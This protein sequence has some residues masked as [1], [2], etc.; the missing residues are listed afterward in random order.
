MPTQTRTHSAQKSGGHRPTI[1]QFFHSQSVFIQESRHR[2]RRRC[3][4]AQNIEVG[5][6]RSKTPQL[7]PIT[8]TSAAVNSEQLPLTAIPDVGYRQ[9]AP[10]LN[11]GCRQ[12]LSTAAPNVS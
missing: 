7:L 1:L 2:T 12:N 5:S 8:L 4:S 6:K 10:A 11:V 9:T 3:K